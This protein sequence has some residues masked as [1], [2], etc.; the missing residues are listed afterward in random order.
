MEIALAS[1]S[2]AGNDDFLIL[3]RQIGQQPFAVLVL[4]KDQRSDGKVQDQIIALPAV[5]LPSHAVLAVLGGIMPFE[6]KVIQRQQAGI[7]AQDDGAAVTAVAAVRAALRNKFLPSEMHAPV[8]TVAG[9]HTDARFI[10]KAYSKP[11]SYFFR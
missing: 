5:H 10:N 1:Q 9:L 3:L 7:G 4:Q 6:A 2:A 11:L 8:A